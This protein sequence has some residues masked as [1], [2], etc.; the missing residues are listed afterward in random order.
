VRKSTSSRRIYKGRTFSLSSIDVF[1]QYLNE[2]HPK[3]LSK[4]WLVESRVINREE[5]V[6]QEVR[7]NIPSSIQKVKCYVFFY[8]VGTKYVVY[9]LQDERGEN[10]FS[11]GL[12]IDNELVHSIRL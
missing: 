11:I 9:L 6:N 1:W 5:I 8:D 10:N 4:D 3:L 7:A 12:L 2:F